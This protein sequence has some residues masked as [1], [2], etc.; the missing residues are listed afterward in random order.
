VANLP[1]V[2]KPDTGEEAAGRCTRW[3]RRGDWGR[4]AP[5]GWPRN[6]GDLP[7]WVEPNSCDED[8]SRRRGG[9]KSAG[10][11]VPKKP[12]NSGGG[13]GPYRVYA[14]ARRKE[15][16]L[17]KQ[18]STTEE[19][20]YLSDAPPEWGERKAVSEKLSHLRRQLY[21]KAKRE[22]KFRFYALYDRIYRKDV[23]WAA[24]EQVR[25]NRGACG[26]DGV[27][28]HQIEHA[29]GGPKRLVDELHE[30]LRSKT[31]KPQP[32]RRVYIP[33]PD[34]RER[35]LGIPCVRDRVVQ[36]A[37]VLILEPVFEAD[38]KDCSYGFRPGR[39]AHHALEEIHAHI[40][41]GLR[42]VYD[43]DLA[44]YFDSIPHQK[45]MAALRMRIV[46]RSVLQLIRLW[47]E[48]VVVDDRNG[49]PARRSHKGTPQ[50]GVI[51]PLL[52][53][54]YLHWLDVLFHAPDGPARWARAKLVRYAD[55]FVILARYQGDRLL[56]W[57]EGVLETRMG[58]EINRKKTRV[59]NLNDAGASLDFLGFTFCYR[60]SPKGY[61]RPMLHVGPS[62]KAV[63]R[64][65][66][67]LRA[68]TDSH[69]CFKPIPALIRGLNRHL[70]GWANYFG[71]FG[72]SRIAFRQINQYA[73]LRL[74]RH[75]RRRSQRPYRPPKGTSFYRHIADLGLVYL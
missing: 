32:V 12:G 44:G 49:G 67:Q 54:V 6:L 52:A 43:A 5:K 66:G 10:L 47:L 38:F 17:S 41:S 59:V 23:L 74:Y 34:G 18:C 57:V 35:P 46:D 22:P 2:A 72:Y 9:Q 56:R 69:M 28:I 27:T 1:K 61:S 68:M 24:W 73:R 3:T 14:V 8:I 51:S 48:A 62:K 53:N 21:L 20:N 29:E 4:R 58:L 16:R 15:S 45:L 71:G 13:T 26:V 75:L 39:S 40:R 42:D 30:S 65:R 25:R 7:A 64:E 36:T 19:P 37:A 33:K 63:A 31:Y 60:P 55:D 11:M 70:A 50:G